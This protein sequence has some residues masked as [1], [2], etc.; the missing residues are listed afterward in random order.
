MAWKGEAAR[1]FRSF[2]TFLRGIEV[3]VFLYRYF[4]WGCFRYFL[5]GC[6]QSKLAPK[7]VVAIRRFRRIA[8]QS[9]LD[10]N[11]IQA[12]A[13]SEAP[14]SPRSLRSTPPLIRRG[15]SAGLSR[16]WSSRNPASRGQ[17]LRL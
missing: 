9:R 17:R 13:W 5:V 15:V 7:I 11:T 16:R 12:G 8:D 14:S 1:G 2:I 6:A 10:P 3:E 4:A